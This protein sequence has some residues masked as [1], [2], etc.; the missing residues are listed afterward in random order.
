MLAESA[1]ILDFGIHIYPYWEDVNEGILRQLPPGEKG[2]S[3]LDV[4]CGQGT[5]AE[6]I[7]KKGYTVWGVECESG[8]VE[9]ARPRVDRVV[10]ADLNDLALV[11]AELAG[12]TFDYI[13]FSDVLEHVY[14]PLGTLRNYIQFLSPNGRILISLPNIA[15]WESRL[16]LLF[17]V[18]KYCS[19][20]IMDRTHIRFFTIKSAKQMVEGTGLKVYKLDHTPYIVRAFVPLIKSLLSKNSDSSSQSTSERRGLIDSPMFRLYQRLVYP[21]ESFFTKLF[22]GLF[23]FRI[24]LIAGK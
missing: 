3:V 8:A 14:D 2:R 22:P 15:N 17:G 1:H 5:L 12:K 21:L 24:I 6:A 11:K 10:P 13:I 19:S 18:F 9:R 16:K 7:R 20:G 4:G 23:T